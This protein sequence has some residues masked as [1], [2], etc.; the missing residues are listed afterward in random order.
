MKISVFCRSTS[1]L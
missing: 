1:F